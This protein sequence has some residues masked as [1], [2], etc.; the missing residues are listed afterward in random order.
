MRA[1]V[2][3]HFQLHKK[4][5]RYGLH[6]PWSDECV[7][8]GVAAV[9]RNFQTGTKLSPTPSH[10][11]SSLDWVNSI[12]RAMCLAFLDIPPVWFTVYVC[13]SMFYL[14]CFT[15]L[16][17]LQ[18]ST[19][20]TTNANVFCSNNINPTWNTL[21]VD[22]MVK[23]NG[24]SPWLELPMTNYIVYIE[25]TQIQVF[26]FIYKRAVSANTLKRIVVKWAQ[27]SVGRSIGLLETLISKCEYTI[28]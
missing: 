10:S 27:L 18:H 25:S 6:A 5:V 3:F 4:G 19:T 8:L 13:V 21:R 23:Q 22:F 15:L 12:S 24:A 28:V 7:V 14:S 2:H 26:R 16:P 20:T 1:H 17:P 9:F 11:M